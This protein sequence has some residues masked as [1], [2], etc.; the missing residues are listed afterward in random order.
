MKR[1]WIALALVGVLKSSS[2]LAIPQEAPTSSSE[3]GQLAVTDEPPLPRAKG[4]LQVH[5]QNPRYFTDGSGK[6]IYLTG[7]HTWSN[8]QDQG[9]TDPPPTFDYDRYL[10]F[11][12]QQ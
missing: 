1:Y 6:A 12:R 8:L 11:L 4:P 3:M 5:P 2:A 9:A 7:S 10:K